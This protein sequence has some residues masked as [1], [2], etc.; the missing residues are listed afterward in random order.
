[1]IEDALRW[2]TL[3]ETYLEVL[4]C[5]ETALVDLL[6]GVMDSSTVD[7]FG[8]FLETGLTF[9]VISGLGNPHKLCGPSSMVLLSM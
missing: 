2:S 4:R 5:L 8:M 1:M 7:A 9:Q 3:D 6:G